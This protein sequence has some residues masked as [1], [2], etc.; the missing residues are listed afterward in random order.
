MTRPD[1]DQTL[2][3]SLDGRMAGVASRFEAAWRAAL[4]GGDR[5]DPGAFLDA[6][7]D[8]DRPALAAELARLARAYEARLAGRPHP[9]AV[10]ADTVLHSGPHAGTD[11]NFSL[12]P[13]ADPARP[14]PN[15]TIQSAPGAAEADPLAGEFEVRTD[16]PAYAATV[17]FTP[18]PA[19]RAA[20]APAVAGYDILGELG[21][22]GM[23]V[24]YKARHVRLNRTVA[25]KMVLAGAHAGADR[26]ARFFTE[27]EAVAQL[28]HPN[29]VQIYEVGEHDGLPYFS[30]EYVAGGSLAQRLGGKPLPARE[31]ARTVRLL[32]DAVASAHAKGVVH[33]DLKPAN[34]LMTEAGEPKITDFGLAK[35]LESD[36]SQ[37]RSGTLMGTP[38]Y[39][40][41][42]QARGDTH[43]VG[44][45]ADVWALGV[46]LYECLTGRTPFVGTS[47]VDTLRQ[48]QGHEPV[49]PGRLEPGTPA[50]L[51]TVCLKC[52]QKEP[53][54][55]Y[56]SAKDLADDLGRF[57]AGRP[58][59]ARP[60]G[61]AERA[62]R[63]CRRNPR[64]AGLTATVLFLL[65]AV[66]AGSVAVAYRIS[67]ER[68][69]AVAARD[70]AD[71]NARRADRNARDELA[72]R[73]LADQK[74]RDEQAARERAD[75]AADE[76]RQARAA[77]DANAKVASDQAALALS[78]LQI[79]VDKVQTQLDDAPRTQRL[80]ADLLRAAMDGLRQVA[81]HA[82]KSSST[83]ATMAAAHM[84]MGHM[85]RQLGDTEEAFRQ[86]QL[87][88]EITRKRAA[89][90]PTRDASQAN[91]AATLTVLGDMSQE[92]RRDMAAALD[93]Y[94][95]AAAVRERVYLRPHGGDGKVDPLVA[96][97]ALAE[98]HTR[99]A[100]TVLRLGDPA[101][102][103]ADFGK[104]LAL[105]EE[106]VRDRPG[107]DALRQDLARTYNALGEVSFRGGDP[108]KARGYFDRCLAERDRLAAAKPDNRR[109]KRELAAACGNSGDFLL[110]CG[111]VAAARP[112]CD[113]SLALSRELADSDPDNAEDRRALAEA[114][115][116]AGVLARAAGDR[117][118]A[119]AHFRDCLAIREEQAK[120]G[121]NDRR[122]AELMLALARAGEPARAAALAAE[123]GRGAA[124]DPELLVE[125]GRAYAGCAAAA[126]DPAL[127]AEYERRAV[128]ALAAAVAAGYRDRVG[129]ETEPDLEPVRGRPE[130]RALSAGLRSP[131]GGPAEAPPPR[132]RGG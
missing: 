38:N 55:R 100:V 44:P 105:R 116:R 79:L 48:V 73:T 104:A 117:A 20:P 25:L 101:G 37:T 66:A 16:D 84:R 41:P 53:A 32:A 78:T 42:E 114:L 72:A 47:I 122:K 131:P 77:A 54:K 26:L 95:Q 96:K 98:A 35:R 88:H 111:D 58:I 109:F 94:R 102:S 87:C 91:L 74:A 108:D 45:A 124:R 63:W 121:K 86:Y 43:A 23:G 69:A 18:P 126:A 99:V 83:E 80:K 89:A 107:N 11:A 60:V 85:F 93:Y 46:I 4:A 12:D 119:D 52:L 1:H 82:E 92:L 62:W 112:L 27:A 68:A 110:R 125:V 13:P 8:A 120:D 81:R 106:L 24:V 14:G 7:P 49:P 29:I 132:E 118:A 115:Y 6:V 64:V 71:E 36:S 123:V 103:A 75:R 34:V 129:L 10:L 61:P 50:D 22:G 90:N 97:Q 5:P 15:G 57:L 76:A 51:E 9:P 2:D 30:L 67:R 39:M 130:F 65:V 21:R 128:E 28:A 113:R 56:G 3:P 33:R 17:G 40:A 19:G 127:R 59:V 70:L 31:A